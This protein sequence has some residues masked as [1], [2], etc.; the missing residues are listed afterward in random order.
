MKKTLLIISAV[1]FAMM[2]SAADKV[3]LT[4]KNSL[5]SARAGEMVEVPFEQ[6]KKKLGGAEQVVVTDADGR[7]IPSQV[8]YDGKLIFQVGVPAKG[9][10]V[11][12]AKAGTPQ[13][14]ESK[15]Y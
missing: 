7:E 12:Y 6:V 5:K 11:Y 8:T 2:A 4:V 13:N 14:Y 1:M 10:S 15:L 3:T 9:K